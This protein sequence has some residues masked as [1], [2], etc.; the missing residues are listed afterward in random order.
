MISCSFRFYN[1][2]VNV[3]KSCIGKIKDAVGNV[4][5][6]IKFFLHFPVTDVGFLTD[7]ES[8][9]SHFV[10]G[11]IFS[12]SNWG[13]KAVCIFQTGFRANTA[14]GN[15]NLKESKV[16]DN[17]YKFVGEFTTSEENGTETFPD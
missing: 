14:G 15:L 13:E 3:I 16:L 6:T 4:A 9:M 12:H 8:W 10:G 2:F 1:G 11:V 7:Y 5:E 17:G